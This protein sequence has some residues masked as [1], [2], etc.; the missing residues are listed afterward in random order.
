MKKVLFVALILAL[1]IIA[2]A[3]SNSSHKATEVLNIN[4]MLRGYFYA[5]SLI[6][7]QRAFGGFGT[8]GNLP[9]AVDPNNSFP[10]GTISLVA[11]PDVETIFAKKYKGLTVLLVNLTSEPVAFNAQD[12]RLY[13]TQEARDTDGK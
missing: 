13:I 11:R 3:Q 4:F 9:K 2:F 12:S 8:S 5:G 7:D 1:N 10:Q 6:E